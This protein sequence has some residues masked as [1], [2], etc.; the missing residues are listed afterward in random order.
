MTTIE[1]LE[2]KAY[3]RNDAHYRALI[4]GLDNEPWNYKWTKNVIDLHRVAGLCV[5]GHPIRFKYEL[6]NKVTGKIVYVGSTCVINY[7]F[8]DPATTKAI[9]KK[10]KEIQKELNRRKAEAKK[11]IQ[12]K[13]IQDLIKIR[14]P[15]IEKLH[16][17]RNQYKEANEYLPYDVYGFSPVDPEK[18]VRLSSCIKALKKD[19]DTLEKMIDVFEKEHKVKIASL[20]KERK[21]QEE[22]LEQEWKEEEE[23][24]ANLK[25]IG[26]IGKDFNF[27]VTLVDKWF[28]NNYD[29]M[30][31]K[32][33]DEEGNII[34]KWGSLKN[35]TFETGCKYS[36]TAKVKK[37]TDWNDEKST[38]IS[39]LKN[40]EK[41]EG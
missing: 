41:I 32:F 18:Y 39:Y 27:V 1:R 2:G 19:I 33:N 31:Y 3:N 21:I 28:N 30:F 12:I 11:N 17:I 40:I 35:I 24:K 38:T 36:F 15:L 13:E 29:S 20:I 10:A 37:H 5:C 34:V 4:E 26:T 8:L 7:Q 25:H 14:K 22:K 9:E 16:E 6:E 23:R